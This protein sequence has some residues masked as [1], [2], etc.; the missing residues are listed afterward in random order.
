MK[1]F[2]PDLVTV[3]GLALVLG[4]I[5]QALVLASSSPSIMDT[6]SLSDISTVVGGVSWLCSSRPLDQSLLPPPRLLLRRLVWEH[7]GHWRRHQVG[8]EVTLNLVNYTCLH[9][10]RHRLHHPL[11]QGKACSQ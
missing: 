5:V 3:C 6:V 1:H 7:Q 10:R 9:F 11:V 4:K 2:L 8:P